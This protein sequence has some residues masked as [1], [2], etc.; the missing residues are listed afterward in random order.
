MKIPG[1]IHSLDPED[2]KQNDHKVISFSFLSWPTGKV[3]GKKKK[4]QNMTC[5]FVKSYI[6]FLEN[7]CSGGIVLC[8][9]I[10]CR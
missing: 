6:I 5:M 10:H 9:A 1:I 8:L 7:N 2:P 4:K 3:E